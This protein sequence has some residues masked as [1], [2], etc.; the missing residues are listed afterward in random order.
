MKK[1]SFQVGT[2]DR[3]GNQLKK[4]GLP[5]SHDD[6]VEEEIIDQLWFIQCDSFPKA[7]S[8]LAQ[9]KEIPTL[10]WFRVSFEEQREME[11]EVIGKRVIEVKWKTVD[12]I[13]RKAHEGKIVQF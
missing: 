13:E 6:L 11:R 5:D 12:S 2:V 9:C 4:G 1:R 8:H 10:D 7:L 3:K